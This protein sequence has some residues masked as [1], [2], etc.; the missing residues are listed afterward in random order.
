MQTKL[1]I[2]GRLVAGE[3]AAETVLD[4]ASGTPVAEVPAAGAG[5]VEAAVTAAEQAFAPWA[6]TAPRERG[7]L[8]LKIAE[9]LEY[10]AEAY[11]ALESRPGTIR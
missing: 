1:L 11:A 5:Q 9:H 7:A 10:H 4:A 6:A 3:G 2:G 8:L